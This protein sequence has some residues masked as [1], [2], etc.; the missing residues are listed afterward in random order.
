MDKLLDP[1]FD[2][3]PLT[4]Y[5]LIAVFCWTEAA[6][7]L[8]FITPGELAVVTGGILASRGQVHFGALL[9]IVFVATVAGN[10]TGFYL[11]RRF[12]D[13]LLQSAFLQRFLSGPIQKAQDF[14]LRRGEW[15]IVVGRIST[16]TRIIT[17]FLAGSAGMSYRRFFVF[18]LIASLLWAF[19]FLTLGYLLGESW[20]LIQEISGTAAMLVLILFVVALVIRWIAV[21]IA[22][23]QRRVKAAFRLAFRVTGTRGVARR[24]RPAFVWLACRLDPRLAQGLSLTICFL[25]LVAAIGGAGLVFSQ[26]E[27]IWGLAR[28]DYPVLEWMVATRT[29]EA[30]AISRAT[31]LAFHWPGMALL[32][33]PVMG[34]VFRYAG[35]VAAL[36]FGVGVIGATGGAFLLDR[37]VLSGHV[38]NAEF[39]SVPVAAVAALLVH[40]TALT[41]RVKDWASAVA[42]SAF[43]SFVVFAVA[44]GTL[45]AGW[46]APSGIALGLALG[47]AWAAALEL[48]WTALQDDSDSPDDS[49]NDADPSAAGEPLDS[50]SRPDP[51]T[52]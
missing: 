39:P 42:C 17:P 6:F 50:G 35:W 21:R 48:P 1:L 26:T 2:L 51:N 23:H 44:L 16:P 10:A 25:A 19:S 7:F 40:A 13:G 46:A 15:A 22:A 4:V 18:D 38:E 30:V 37:F 24:L 34:L 29:D 33:I 27:E 20:G 47:M 31:L 9:G 14:M 41:A 12:G 49:D 36:R 28:I 32:M 45:V 43:A 52:A 11:G 5:L 3:Q 8:G